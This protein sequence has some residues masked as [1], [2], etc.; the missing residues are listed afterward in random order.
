MAPAP[1]YVKIL[2]A[3]GQLVLVLFY[4]TLGTVFTLFLLIR[5]GREK[6]FRRVARPSPP[7]VALDPI[8]GEHKMLKL[9]VSYFILLQI[10]RHMYIRRSL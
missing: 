4:G 5:N 3:V 2:L 6:F 1:A 8:Y 9:K 7:Q 10:I